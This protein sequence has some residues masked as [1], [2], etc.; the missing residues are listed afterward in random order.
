MTGKGTD[1]VME[2]RALALAN[3]L[4]AREENAPLGLEFKN[5]LAACKALASTS[6]PAA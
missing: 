6:K 3:R 2:Q 1:G 4:A 5:A